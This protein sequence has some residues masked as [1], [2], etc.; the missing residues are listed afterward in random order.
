MTTIVLLA[1]GKSTRMGQDKSMM[2]GGVNRIF[3]ICDSIGNH[4]IITLCGNRS[5]ISLFKGEV[6]PDPD[7]LKGS[8][9]IIKWLLSFIEDDI[10]MIPCDAFN[11]QKEGIMYLLGISNGIPLDE[12]HRRQPLL[13]RIT[14]RDLLEFKASNI[15]EFLIN[16]PSIVAPEVSKQYV[17]FNTEGDLKNYQ[18]IGDFK[19][20]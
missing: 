13:A 18:T 14:D 10:L 19:T 15:N 1:G 7:E 8:F 6:L 2:N 12:N 11:L 20:Q 3:S 16:L 4:R 9:E 5:R 17:N